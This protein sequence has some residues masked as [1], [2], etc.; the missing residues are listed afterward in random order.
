MDTNRF[1]DEISQQAQSIL[2]E[3][4]KIAGA[5]EGATPYRS[6]CIDLGCSTAAMDYLESLGGKKKTSYFRPAGNKDYIIESVTL[7]LDVVQIKAQN[8]DAR[9]PTAEETARFEAGEKRPR[10]ADDYM[11]ATLNAA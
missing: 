5:A 1:T 9:R 11:A 4:L 2:S 7:D 6:L 8:S 10:I 3:C